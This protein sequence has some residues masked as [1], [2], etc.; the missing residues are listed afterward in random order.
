MQQHY[1]DARS[2][3]RHSRFVQSETKAINIDKHCMAQCQGKFAQM[4]SGCNMTWAY[5]P[6]MQWGL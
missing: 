6:G 5:A 4:G 1:A 3:A 2:N